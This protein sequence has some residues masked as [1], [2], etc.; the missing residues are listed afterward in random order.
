MNLAANE[1][2]AEPTSGAKPALPYFLLVTIKMTKTNKN[3]MIASNK[4]AYPAVIFGKSVCPNPSFGKPKAFMK[5]DNTPDAA[6][7][8]KN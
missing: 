1:A 2:I 8:P 5:I 3:V 7:A 6:M 4:N